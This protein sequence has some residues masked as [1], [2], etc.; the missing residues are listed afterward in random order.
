MACGGGGRG[1]G[2]GG[3]CCGGGPGARR[4]ACESMTTRRRRPP[5]PPPPPAVASAA[6]GPL[7]AC[8]RWPAAG[9]APASPRGRRSRSAGPAVAGR[10]RC[11]APAAPGPCARAVAR[12]GGF[13]RR[14]RALD[15]ALVDARGSRL[16]VEAGRLEDR[17]HLLAGDPRLLG[18]LMNA[19]LCHQRVCARTALRRARP[20]ALRGRAPPPP[21][22]CPRQLS[23]RRRP[24]PRTAPRRRL[25]PRS[26]WPPR[27]RRQSPF[28]S[29]SSVMTGGAPVT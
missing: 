6:L 14:E 9:A 19:L 5:P 21:G 26:R 12:Q 16:H 25:A 8:C 24:Q 1:R 28:T 13:G 7:R 20:L 22:W 23:P 18:Y 2:G 17:E 4:E 29:T 11:P 15:V 3:C 10:S 27:H